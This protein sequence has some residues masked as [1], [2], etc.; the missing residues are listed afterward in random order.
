[1]RTPDL[2][3]AIEDLR[4][5]SLETH[6]ELLR[7]LARLQAS[8]PPTLR[9]LHDV[10]A[11]LAYLRLTLRH[12]RDQASSWSPPDTA[13]PD[14]ATPPPLPPAAPGYSTPSR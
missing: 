4:R 11:H 12:A 7:L 10:K 8:P 3:E 1:M 9:A 14:H 13:T 6:E 5:S 2:Q